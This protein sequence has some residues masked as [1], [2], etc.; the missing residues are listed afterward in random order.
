MLVRASI[1]AAL[2]LAGC[3]SPD[4]NSAEPPPVEIDLRTQTPSGFSRFVYPVE[5]CGTEIP[6]K[7]P[8]EVS[9][10]GWGSADIRV[11]LALLDDPSVRETAAGGPWAQSRISYAFPSR[12]RGTGMLEWFDQG[13]GRARRPLAALA[14][15]LGSAASRRGPGGIDGDTYYAGAVRPG[16]DAAIWCTATDWPNSVCRAEIA[17]GSAGTRY[18][19][20]FPSKVAGRLDRIV[21]IG[22][23]LFKDAAAAC[24]ALQDRKI[25]PVPKGRP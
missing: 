3:G 23:S 6:L 7:P 17:T 11:P 25:G 8:F 18:L 22:D 21:E 4:P 14:A 15:T 20:V 16:R 19:A 2:L 13:E 10:D 12:Y 5:D 1:P 24:V 9:E